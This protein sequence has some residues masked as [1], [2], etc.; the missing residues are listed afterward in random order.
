MSREYFSKCCKAPLDLANIV[1]GDE[2]GFVVRARCMKCE[3]ICEV[4]WLNE[5]TELNFKTKSND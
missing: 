5:G 1:G 3:K 2:V 4:L